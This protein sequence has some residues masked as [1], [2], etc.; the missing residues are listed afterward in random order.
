MEVEGTGQL[1]LELG[2]VSMDEGTEWW[3]EKF[4]APNS[5]F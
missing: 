2:V 5:V 4:Q 3:R 1:L